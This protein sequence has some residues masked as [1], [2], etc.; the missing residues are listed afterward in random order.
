MKT[1][2]IKDNFGQPGQVRLTGEGRLE[3]KNNGQRLWRFIRYIDVSL[4]TDKDVKNAL[5]ATEGISQVKS[6][7]G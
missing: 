3:V 1:W 7:R 2:N 6:Q 4:F 5:K